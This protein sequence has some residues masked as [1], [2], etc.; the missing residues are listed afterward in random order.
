[1]S[2]DPLLDALANKLFHVFSRAEYAL[3]AAGFNC[4]D[5]KA[6]ANWDAFARKLVDLVATPQSED[7]R[8]AVEF[9]LEYPPKQQ[10]VI[11]GVL[12]WKDCRP[13]GKTKA[14]SLFLYIR[15]VRNNLFHGGKFNG[16]WFEP[17]RSE[18]L[19]K[20]SLTIIHAAIETIPTVKDAYHG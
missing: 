16:H 6:K 19:I 4:G 14:E 9:M 10:M 11:H 7:L 1:M 5:G 18:M 2:D 17:E 20:H 3:K 12:S 15:R 8:M 13:T